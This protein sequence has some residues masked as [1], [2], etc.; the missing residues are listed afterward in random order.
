[1]AQRHVVVPA[2][3]PPRVEEPQAG[4]NTTVFPHKDESTTV[5]V[6]PPEPRPPISIPDQVWE[7]SPTHL[8]RPIHDKGKQPLLSDLPV[9]P[10][11]SPFVPNSVDLSSPLMPRRKITSAIRQP[12]PSRREAWSQPFSHLALDPPHSV[13][14]DMLQAHL[15]N[16][17]PH[18]SSPFFAVNSYWSFFSFHYLLLVSRFMLCFIF[19]GCNG[20][21]SKFVL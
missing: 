6:K 15:K 9:L 16:Y 3:P 8:H 19:F 12:R 7:N 14:G 11:K 10:P 4:E 2:P 21:G 5:A 13:S 20:E 17:A 1:M 18:S